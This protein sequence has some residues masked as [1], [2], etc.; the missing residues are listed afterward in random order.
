MHVGVYRIRVPVQCIKSGSMFQVDMVKTENAEE[1]VIL[2]QAMEVVR[3]ELNIE[4]C[5]AM[6]DKV[7]RERLSQI[8]AQRQPEVTIDGREASPQTVRKIQS[9]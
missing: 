6:A 4:Q 9:L 8:D 7:Y 1:E 2:E 3:E 5:H